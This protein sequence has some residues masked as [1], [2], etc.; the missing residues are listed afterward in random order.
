MVIKP[1]SIPQNI[2][3]ALDN[4]LYC[5][6]WTLAGVIINSFTTP[7]FLVAT[8]PIIISFYLV[9]RFYIASSR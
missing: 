4:F 8:I 6:L 2:A 7:Y 9:Q 5:S 1:I 3:F